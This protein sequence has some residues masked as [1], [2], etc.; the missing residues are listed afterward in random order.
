M[1]MCNEVVQSMKLSIQCVTVLSC[2]QFTLQ[3][4]LCPVKVLQPAMESNVT[5]SERQPEP[6]LMEATGPIPC[7]LHINHHSDYMDVSVVPS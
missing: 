5:F 7:S 3:S 6:S 2:C 4:E 1:K